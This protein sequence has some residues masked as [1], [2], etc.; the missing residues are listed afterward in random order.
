MHGAPTADAELEALLAEDWRDDRRRHP[1]AAS[2]D[3]DRSADGRWEDQ[4]ETALAGEA[5][6]RRRVLAR[7]E[8]IPR[9]ALSDSAQLDRELYAGQLRDAL[10]GY[11]LGAHFFA[12]DP[13]EGVHT[14]AYYAEQLPFAG[15]AEY[16]SWLQ[17]LDAYP[18]A[19]DDAIALL[20]A[21]IARELLWPRAS[22]ERL[23][24]QLDRLVTEPERSAFY[25]PFARIPA[26]LGAAGAGGLR[27]RGRRA[28]AE[29]VNPALRALRA[30]VVDEYLPAAPVHA[31]M[32]HLP[33]GDAL[34]AYFS[35]TYTTTDLTPDAIHELGVREVARIRA[36]ME[37]LAP[38]TGYQGS[39]HD[40]FA[41][42]RADPANYY[43]T[44]EALLAAYRNIA[45]RIDPELVKVFR[46]LP[47]MPYGVVPIP[48]ALAPDTTTAYY[49]P[50]ALDGSRAGSYYVNLYRPEQRP[51]YEMMAL[52]LHECV[53]GHHLQIALAQELQ[54]LPDF[55]R[56]SNA[57]TAYVEGWGL[58]AESLGDEMGLYD[59]PKSKFGA[60]TYQMWRAVR[61]VVDTG[62]HARGWS[63]ARAVD[64]FLDNAAKTRLDVENEIDRYI[65]RP[66]Q[67]LAYKIGE[68]KIRELRE[69]A[70]TRLGA[71]FD[72]RDFHDV[73]LGAGALPLDVL[74]TR[75]GN[76]LDRT[77]C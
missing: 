70:R 62:I 26:S 12:L 37:A 61:L 63:R 76:W 40:V 8:T 51:I 25:S 77:N 57:Y 60:L 68:L 3:G 24:A 73:V 38:Q 53:P 19:V 6:H 43:P 52:S 42:F 15:A 31:G 7:L 11:E 27:E 45:K 59:D 32:T 4:S 72:L 28:I 17:R 9:A 49:Y 13:R 69:R 54:G 47:R 29:R 30:F 16:E 50:G 58:Y 21:A 67:A 10:R 14:Y 48:A 64:Y 22:I 75:V 23:P 46:T 65:T 2:L 34:Y 20:R 44:G 55:R 35:H 33:G 1:L 36:E 56:A 66:G 74:E 5:A 39:L 71:R 41:Q 18:R